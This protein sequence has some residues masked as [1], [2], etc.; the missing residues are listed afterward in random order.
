MDLLRNRDPKVALGSFDGKVAVL[1][2]LQGENYFITTNTD[3]VPA[4]PSLQLPHALFLWSDMRYGTDDPTL[5]PQ[6]YTA[7]FCH[8]PAIAKKGARPEP[9]MMWWNPSPEDF[10]VQSAVTRKLGRPRNRHQFL[11]FVNK[12][13]ALCRNLRRTSGTPISPLFGELVQN[14][15][16]LI[17]QLQTLASTYTKTVFAVTSLQRACLKLDALYNYITVYKPRMENYLSTPPDSAHTPV[18]QCIGTFTSIPA[19]AQQLW[20]ARLPFWFL[21]PTFVF[22]CENRLSVVALDEPRFNVP[23]TLDDEAPP[24]VYSANSTEEKIAAIHS[25]VVRTLWYRDPFGTTDSRP[26]L[27]PTLSQAARVKFRA[28]TTSTRITSHVCLSWQMYVLHKLY[29]NFTDPSKPPGK[30]QVKGPAT[31]ELPAKGPT[32]TDW[33]KFQYLNIP[34]MPPSIAPWADALAQVNKSVAPFTSD[35]ADR[36]YVFPEPALLVNTMHEPQHKFLHHWTL[37][38]DGFAY[39]LSQPEHSQLLSTQEWRDILEGHMTKRGHPD[40][41][42]YR[43]SAQLED[44]KHPALQAC[45]ITSAEGFPVPPQSLPEFSVAQTRQIV[46]E[47]GE[48]NFQFEF[49]ALDRRASMKH[50]LDDIKTCFAGRMLIGA[51]LEMSKDGFALEKIEQR[52]RYFVWAATLMLDWNTKSPRPHLITRG[53]VEHSNWTPSQMEGLETVVCQYYMQAFWEHFGRAAVI[54]LRLDNDVEKEEGEI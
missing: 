13:V 47:V 4:L 14:I 44:R 5:W 10:V 9:D 48:T 19:I 45:N 6:Q 15:P 53:F 20:S 30:A 50:R 38:R 18:V 42:T 3:Y 39:I 29:L 16:M 43:R 24:G 2:T 27:Q 52:H 26:P 12:L 46:W 36:Q 54:P 25:A 1:A 7:H 34:E 28:H 11:P 31:T 35:P 32:K 51:P 41:K 17:E 37:L 40:S 49:C 8:L 33:D 23:D 21:R 22:D